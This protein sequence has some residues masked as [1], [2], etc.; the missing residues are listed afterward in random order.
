MVKVFIIAVVLAVHPLL[1]V[2]TTCAAASTPLL[3]IIAN[4]AALLLLLVPVLVFVSIALILLAVRWIGNAVVDAFLLV[5]A[6]SSATASILLSA[7]FRGTT[8]L[9]LAN[10]LFT[11]ALDVAILWLNHAVG[12]LKRAAR[13]FYHFKTF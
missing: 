10:L 1:V 5:G 6:I 2:S 3:A 12:L 9:V 4:K 13:E 8:I 7:T 11:L